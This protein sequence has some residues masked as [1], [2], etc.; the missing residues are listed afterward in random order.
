MKRFEITGR[1]LGGEVAGAFL[2]SLLA[3]QKPT[4]EHTNV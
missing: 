2:H 4:L 3:P 1:G